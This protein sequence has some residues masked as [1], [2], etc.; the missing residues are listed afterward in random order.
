MPDLGDAVRVQTAQPGDRCQFEIMSV[1]GGF[2]RLAYGAPIGFAGNAFV[3]LAEVGIGDGIASAGIDRRCQQLAGLIIITLAQVNHC[4]VVARLRQPRMIAD[5]IFIRLDRL[6]GVASHLIGVSGEEPCG[7][8][9]RRLLQDLLTRR[10]RFGILF[11]HHQ[12]LHRIGSEN[13]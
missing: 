9:I 3:H 4:Q 11:L 1:C 10:D 5:Q 8:V 6:V 13:R 2:T 12:L 7:C